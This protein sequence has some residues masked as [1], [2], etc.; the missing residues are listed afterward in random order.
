MRVTR[1]PGVDHRTDVAGSGSSSGAS[2]WAAAGRPRA[3][4]ASSAGWSTGRPR[5]TLTT[6]DPGASARSTAPPTS[7]RVAAVRGGHDQRVGAVAGGRE[8]VGAVH[9]VDAGGHP[10]PG[11]AADP[12]LVR[13]ERCEPERHR[14]AERAQAEDHPPDVPELAE[15]GGPPPAVAVLAGEVGQALGMGEQARHHQL[16]DGQRADP[17]PVVTVR[18]DRPPIASRSWSIPAALVC[19]QLTSGCASSARATAS[20]SPKQC[21]TTSSAMDGRPPPAASGVISSRRSS[22]RAAWTK[23][24]ASAGSSPTTRQRRGRARSLAT[25]GLLRALTDGL[26]TPPP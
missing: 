26:R 16:E 24:S 18:P 14:G 21:Q 8:P 7:P 5:A 23:A 3:R 19:R 12:H 17:H 4:P 22:R 6:T 9:P 13:P 20:G 15:V 2:R 11:V 1:T 25:V 10:P